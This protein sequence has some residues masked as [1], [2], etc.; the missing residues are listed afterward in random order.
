MT[1]AT[2]SGRHQSRT[3]G[4]L[5]CVLC[6]DA[7]PRED[8]DWCAAVRG[9]V[10]EGCCLRL[11]T[12]DPLARSRTFHLRGRALS[13]DEITAACMGCE[14]LVRLVTDQTLENDPLARFRAH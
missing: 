9:I 11:M 12:G 10:C 14:R 4:A 1:R 5:H 2:E 8:G 13:D 7:R 6:P 3:D